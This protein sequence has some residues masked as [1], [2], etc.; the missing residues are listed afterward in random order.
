M[1]AS[2][3]TSFE[4]SPSPFVVSTQQTVNQ[5]TIDELTLLYHEFMTKFRDGEISRKEYTAIVKLLKDKP[6]YEIQSL[7]QK[8]IY[9][10]PLVARESQSNSAPASLVDWLY[11]TGLNIGQKLSGQVKD[12]KHPW[13]VQKYTVVLQEM[14]DFLAEAG[15]SPE[16]FAQKF[17]HPRTCFQICI[18]R[19]IQ[20]IYELNL[21]HYQDDRARHQKGVVNELRIVCQLIAEFEGVYEDP[22]MEVLNSIIVSR[23]GGV[24]NFNWNAE[25]VAT[26][27]REGRRE[28]FRQY[29]IDETHL[30][31]EDMLTLPLEWQYAAIEWA[32][33]WLKA[34][35]ADLA[36]GRLAGHF[37]MGFSGWNNIPFV[38]LHYGLSA[39]I[40]MGTPTIQPVSIRDYT[41]FA[42]E[43]AFFI[44]SLVASQ[45][46]FLYV[47]LQI[48]FSTGAE[49]SRTDQIRALHYENPSTFRLVMLDMDSPFYYQTHTA[50]ML[51]T[52]DNFREE[53]F[54]IL[55]QEG[56]HYELGGATDE[57]VFI[58]FSWIE[59]TLFEGQELL[60]QEER[61][62]YIDVFYA[63]FV[64]R[65]I[66][67]QQPNYFTIVCKDGL[68]RAGCVNALL[69]DLILLIKGEE[70]DAFKKAIHV[71]NIHAPTIAVKKIA[72]LPVRRARYLQANAHLYDPTIKSKF[73]KMLQSNF[74]GEHSFEVVAKP[75]PELASYG[76]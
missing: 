31:E 41:A 33:K 23:Y 5:S 54:I 58:L 68:D 2:S 28:L 27:I 36:I 56:T 46:T 4:R 50:N 72:M 15:W 29:H 63:M 34:R 11:S 24:Y 20:N 51:C 52:I 66:Q 32:P 13:K 19:I 43:F 65:L 21:A 17:P 39:N 25:L 40:R 57:D 22:A 35:D 67:K 61:Q 47:N 30:E 3:S 76:V 1:V 38:A 7:Y 48:N 75:N 53:F 42:P 45:Q 74:S 26:F 12:Y 71:V 64:L 55:F 18:D 16:T 8:V 44:K 14:R 9:G 6:S 62:I 70:N 37:G 59:S 69:R 10:V 73:Q 60:T 49:K